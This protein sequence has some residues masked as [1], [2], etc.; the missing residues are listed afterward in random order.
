MTT[1]DDFPFDVSIRVTPEIG[2]MILLV[3][4]SCLSAVRAALPFPN[5]DRGWSDD[6]PGWKSLT[7]DLD[8]TVPRENVL[9]IAVELCN[10]IMHACPG[11]RVYGC[12][13]PADKVAAEAAQQEAER[14]GFFRPGYH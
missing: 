5:P 3:R 7:M 10:D 4:V 2:V 11:L 6:W 1:A 12:R 13:T 9:P 14:P 8:A